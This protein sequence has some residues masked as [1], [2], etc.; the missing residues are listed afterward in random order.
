MSRLRWSDEDSLG[1]SLGGSLVDRDRYRYN[2]RNQDL[3][4][5]GLTFRQSSLKLD[6]YLRYFRVEQ[7]HSRL[8][9]RK[10]SQTDS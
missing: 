10:V 3:T 7:P 5:Q 2:P 6:E 8:E 9:D 4:E 1:G